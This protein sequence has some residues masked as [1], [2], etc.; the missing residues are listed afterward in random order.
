MPSIY[1]KILGHDLVAGEEKEV[2]T[3][4][5]VTKAY[6]HSSIIEMVDFSTGPISIDY[7]VNL[8]IPLLGIHSFLSGFVV[9]FDFPQ[10]VVKLELPD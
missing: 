8:S 1:A 2:D 7:M 5:G 4:N 9:I 3:G 10:R 6:K